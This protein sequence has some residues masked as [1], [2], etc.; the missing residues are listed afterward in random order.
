MRIVIA[1]PNL[2]P[3][4]STFEEAL[5]EGSVTSW[6]DSWN[7]HAV[8]TDLKDADVYVGPNSPRPWALR[9]EPA[10]GPRSRRR[11]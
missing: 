7:E 3:Q 1:D 2:M 5:P 8:L 6:H 10:A 11:F 9:P 4:R